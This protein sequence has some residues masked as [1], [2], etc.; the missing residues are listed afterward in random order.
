[1][2]QLIQFSTASDFIA[3]VDYVA[4]TALKAQFLKF[5]NIDQARQ[6]AMTALMRGVDMLEVC[7]TFDIIGGRLSKKAAAMLAELKARGGKHKVLSRTPELASI[8]YTY[9]GQTQV[10][11]LSW[12]QIKDEDY[13]KEKDGKTYKPRYASPHGRMQMLWARLVSDSVRTI[14]PEVT[15]GYYTPEEMEDII[16]GESRTISV[17]AGSLPALGVTTTATTEPTQVATQPAAQSTVNAQVDVMITAEQ[18]LEVTN[19]I[20]MLGLTQQQVDASLAARN[21]KTLAE[22]TAVQGT[23]IINKLRSL[24][25]SNGTTVQTTGPITQELEAKIQ[26]AIKVCAQIEGGMAITEAVQ[27]HLQKHG[28]GIHQLTYSE[29]QQLLAAVEQRQVRLFLDVALNGTQSGKA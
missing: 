26:E 8:E 1:M 17:N 11:S 27:T 22:L 29:G 6:L 13:T 28:L 15:G 7:L 19:L 25:P 24:L 5:N 4:Q 21:V 2:G 12:D 18:Q 14:A 23:E 16:D 3:T 10:F 9:D 20:T